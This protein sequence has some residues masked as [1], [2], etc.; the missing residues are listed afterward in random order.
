MLQVSGVSK[1]YG[2]TQVLSNVS[3]TVNPGQRVGLIG[4]NGCGKTTLLR[5]ISGDE[6]ANE[7]SVKLSPGTTLGYL[8]QALEY[9]PTATVEDMVVSAR[10]GLRDA[11]RKLGAIEFATIIREEFLTGTAITIIVVLLI[12]LVSPGKGRGLIRR[13][14]VCDHTLLGRGKYCSECGSKATT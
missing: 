2:G 8:W 14:P 5:I 13:C 12:L 10:P 4:P 3:F 7:G 6:Y 11:Q 9:A 1:R